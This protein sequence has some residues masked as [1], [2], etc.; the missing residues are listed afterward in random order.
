MAGSELELRA[1]ETYIGTPT[2]ARHTQEQRVRAAASRG[3]DLIQEV[4]ECR[5]TIAALR[6]ENEQLRRE[7]DRLRNQ[8]AE[9]EPN[10]E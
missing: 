5:D 3:L 7:I 4:Q 6:E 2:F 1:D 9:A 8:P 10:N